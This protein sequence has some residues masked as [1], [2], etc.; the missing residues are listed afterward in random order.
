[1]MADARKQGEIMLRQAGLI[2]VTS[3][4]QKHVPGDAIHEM[5][6]ARMGAD[7]RTSVLNKWNQAHEAPNLFVTDGSQMNSIS[8][9]NPSLTFMAMTARAADYAVK[10][11]K[12]AAI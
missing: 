12:A 10:Q 6:G 5:G 2:N 1:M 9:V 4:E 7:P 8:C 11:M 3:Y